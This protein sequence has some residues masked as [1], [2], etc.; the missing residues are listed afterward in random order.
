MLDKHNII[1]N[2]IH[3]CSN[4][5]IAY[6]KKNTNMLYCIILKSALFGKYIKPYIQPRS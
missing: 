4:L 2:F 5:V 6:R 3:E 1:Y